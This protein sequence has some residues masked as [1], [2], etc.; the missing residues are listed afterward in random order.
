MLSADTVQLTL[1]GA[2]LTL[3]ALDFLNLSRYLEFVLDRIRLSMDFIVKVLLIIP[4]F[5]INLLIDTGEVTRNTKDFWDSDSRI[6]VDILGVF[7]IWSLY[8]YFSGSRELLFVC[9]FYTILVLALRT[10]QILLFFL[11]FVGRSKGTVGSIGILV[12][13]VGF[14]FELG[15]HRSLSVS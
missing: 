9:V 8:L 11:D 12:S 14:T 10:I 3:A 13:I 1:E 4:F 5:L 7:S 15:L 6:Y 2:G